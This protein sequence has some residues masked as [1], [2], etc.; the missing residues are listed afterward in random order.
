M[1]G[2]ARL[3][4]SHTIDLQLPPSYSSQAL[5]ASCILIGAAFEQDSGRGSLAFLLTSLRYVS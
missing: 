5:A 1:L 3:G 4:C 2:A